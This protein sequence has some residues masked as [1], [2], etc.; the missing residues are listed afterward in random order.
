MIKASSIA[1]TVT[2][3]DIMNY[4]SADYTQNFDFFVYLLAS[5]AYLAMTTALVNVWRLLE[6]KINPPVDY[7]W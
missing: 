2:I 5:M 4:T 6:R 7:S 1:S 3:F